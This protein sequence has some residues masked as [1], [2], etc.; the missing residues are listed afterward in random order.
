[1]KGKNL[2][3]KLSLIALFAIAT[4]SCKKENGI[5]NNNVIQRPYVLYASDAVGNIINSNDGENFRTIFSGD[6]KPLRAL[7]TSKKNIL[8]VKE[9]T[10]FF[11]ENEGKLFNPIKPILV[12][13]PS[14]ILWPYFILDIPSLNRIYICNERIGGVAQTA[15]SPENGTY[16][17]PDT[18]WTENDTPLI[19]ESFT[20]ADNKIL[21]GYSQ[22]GSLFAGNKLF[23][24]FEKDK[25]WTPV[26]TDLPNTAG[27]RYYLSHTGSRLVATD[28]NAISTGAYYSDDSGKRFK[29]Y[30]G[31]P[32]GKTIHCTYSAYQTLLVGTSGNG[33]YRTSG[34]AF[35]AANSGIPANTTVYSIV[36]KDNLYKNDAVN[37]YFYIATNKGIYKSEDLAK[38]WV[39]VKDGDYRLLY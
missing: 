6:G 33:V 34:T 3:G 16:F 24:K 22:T 27:A 14:T 13:V 1:M 5:D 29:P 11:S 37:K 10:V 32:V 26:Y 38:S 35:E 31:L 39:K 21:F 19:M 8:I 30:T 17:N 25:V 12:Q 28:Y 36:A 23:A 2:L 9:K 7:I 15:I 20:Y 18:S 4:Q